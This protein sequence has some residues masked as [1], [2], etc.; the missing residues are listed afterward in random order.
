MNAIDVTK[1]DIKR[2][3]VPKRIFVVPY[4]GREQ[5]KSLFLR[6]MKYVLR[7]VPKDDY[8][9]ILVHQK[10][11]RIFNRGAMK[12]LG[13]VWAR[14]KYPQNYRDITFVFNDVDTMPF[15]ENVFSYETEMNKA[16]HFFGYKFAFGGIFAIKGANFERINGFPNYWAWGMEDNAIRNRW[17]R[18]FGER[19]IDYSEFIEINDEEKMM[20][21]MYLFHGIMKTIDINIANKLKGDNGLAGLMTLRDVH[22]D[23][24][25]MDDDYLLDV[26][27]FTCE[28]PENDIEL[29]QNRGGRI[30]I[31]KRA[32]G[33]NRPH[34]PVLPI[35]HIPQHPRPI[36]TPQ[37]PET[38]PN[39]Q[40]A[41]RTSLNMYRR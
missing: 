4:R 15:D 31:N 22:F 39:I 32:T 18:I 30:P 17:V 29:V 33:V 11:D 27:H 8:K 3:I 34:T 5:H 41:M 26:T 23:D 28:Y 38:K 37:Q 24:S 9:L 35:A 1:M 14:N 20:N 13:F 7:N 25:H 10:D 2:D 6:Q 16:K 40:Y 21:M 12:N 19:S 36:M